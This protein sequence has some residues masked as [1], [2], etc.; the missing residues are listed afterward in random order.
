VRFSIGPSNL[1]TNVPVL[2]LKLS[3][4]VMQHGTLGVI[5]SL[6]RLGV[7]VYAMVEDRFAPPAM[8]RYIAGSFLTRSLLDCGEIRLAKLIQVGQRLGRPT[9][10][11]PTDDS[12]SVFVAEHA[13]TLAKWFLLPRIKTDLPRRL[14]NKKELYSICRSFGVPCPEATF[15]GC[16]DDVYEFIERAKFPLVIKARETY[17]L[18]KGVPSVRI[19]ATPKAVLASYNEAEAAGIHDLFIQEYIPDCC[20]EDWIFHGYANP[21]TGYSIGFTGRK[22]RSYPPFAGS[23]TLGVSERNDALAQQTERLLKA[24]G[25]AGIMD[26]DYRLDKRDGRYKLLDFNPRIGAN[27]RMFT[28]RD[29]LD[30]IRAQ[31]L[32]L[33]RRAIH[34]TRGIQARTFVVEP[35]DLLASIGYLRRRRLTVSGWCL[36]LKGRIERAWF[37]A[38]DPIPFLVMCIR[39]LLRGVAR[40]I[41]R[42]GER[43]HSSWP[44]AETGPTDNERRP[45][46]TLG[47][48]K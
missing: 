39:L 10:L 40:L 26:L 9:V 12:G 29:G 11:V 25:Y 1:D 4:N 44:S 33:T 3:H 48:Y 28:D 27:F 31:H 2:L 23:T 46:R 30:V 13:D 8:S 15:P 16:L 7:P 6:G 22:L 17:K 42:S 21:E 20:A 24:I 18:P 45:T 47:A 38:D 37:S 32:D 5:R 14:A 34:L 19:A 35:Y 41:A 36:S 43:S